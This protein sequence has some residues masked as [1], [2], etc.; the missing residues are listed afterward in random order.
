MK[1]K[2]TVKELVDEI[3]WFC[4]YSD[5]QSEENIQQLYFHYYKMFQDYCGRVPIFEII[6]QKGQVK[7]GE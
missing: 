5:A 1:N 6:N 4:R 3:N 2:M 7:L